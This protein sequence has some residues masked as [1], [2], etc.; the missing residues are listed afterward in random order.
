MRRAVMRM[1]ADL[2]NELIRVLPSRRRI[3][4]IV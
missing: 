2:S 3:L 4:D 1:M